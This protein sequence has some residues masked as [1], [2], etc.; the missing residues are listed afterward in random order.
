VG[1]KGVRKSI[2]KTC[3][4]HK[5]VG[6][7]GRREGIRICGTGRQVPGGKIQE[8]DSLRTEWGKNGWTQ[9]LGVRQAKNRG[10]KESKGGKEVK[11]Y[12]KNGREG[13]ASAVKREQLSMK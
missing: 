12:F 11:N 6:R 8:K 3:A 4:K 13:E 7:A 10:R 1:T 9:G 2:A 5:N